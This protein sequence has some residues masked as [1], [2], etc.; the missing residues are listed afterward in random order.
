[1]TAPDSN[2]VSIDGGFR[3]HAQ[4]LR[5][6]L[7][8]DPSARVLA[9]ENRGTTSKFCR[10]LTQIGKPPLEAHTGDSSHSNSPDS[11]SCHPGTLRRSWGFLAHS[12]GTLR[13]MPN[14]K[15]V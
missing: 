2:P 1:C 4:Q 7:L 6:Q 9:G 14:S 15:M 13:S 5:R 11:P 12:R 10:M 8:G 3:C